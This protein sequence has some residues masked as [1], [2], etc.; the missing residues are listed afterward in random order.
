M[1]TSKKS[2]TD[3]PS[4]VERSGK[5]ARETWGKTHD[6]AVE[7]YS[8]GERAHRDERSAAVRMSTSIARHLR[9]AAPGGDAIGR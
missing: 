8:E 5:K 6:S 7:Q 4:T 1:P 3:L 2:D 9:V